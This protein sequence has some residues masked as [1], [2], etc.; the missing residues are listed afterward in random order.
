MPS[1]PHW[2]SQPIIRLLAFLEQALLRFTQL[3]RH[4]LV[5][6]TAT[7]LTR[8]RTELVAEN[9]LLRQ[10]LIILHRQAEK[11]RF[12]QSDRLWLV[13]LASRVQHW[14]DILLILKPDTLLYSVHHE[15]GFEQM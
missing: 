8:S 9:A 13:L 14:K 5:L 2:L 1:I 6:S 3:S 11:P 4:S 10:Q 12:T 15:I 7:D